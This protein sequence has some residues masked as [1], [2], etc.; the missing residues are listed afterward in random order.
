MSRLPAHLMQNL[1][2]A[3][4]S[5]NPGVHCKTKSSERTT[6]KKEKKRKEKQTKSNSFVKRKELYTRKALYM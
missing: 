4:S 6:K 3:L 5:T 1:L 2:L